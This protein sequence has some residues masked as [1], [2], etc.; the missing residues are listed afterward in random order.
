M[1][2]GGFYFGLEISQFIL[3]IKCTIFNKNNAGNFF[4]AQFLICLTNF[5]VIKALLVLSGWQELQYFPTTKTLKEEKYGK[6]APL[7]EFKRSNLVRH[8]DCDCIRTLP[9]PWQPDTV[10]G[11][12]EKNHCIYVEKILSFLNWKVI[13]FYMWNILS[14]FYLFSDS[15]HY[16]WPVNVS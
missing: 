12:K 9:S 7:L 11:L 10:C 3:L 1:A 13:A 15:S 8:L 5:A 4:F 14:N 16:I 6:R 2:K